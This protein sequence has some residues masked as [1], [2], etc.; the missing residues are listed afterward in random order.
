MG[1]RF[2]TKK[3]PQSRGIHGSSRGMRFAI[4]G[5]VANSRE[6]LQERV[7]SPSEI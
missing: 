3:A 2:I 1:G 6:I 4:E 5:V 7:L